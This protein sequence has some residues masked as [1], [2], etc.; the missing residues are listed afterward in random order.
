MKLALTIL[1]PQAQIYSGEA[2]EIIVPTITGEIGILPNHVSLLTQ[3]L[4]GELRVKNAGKTSSFA[5]MGG[6]LEVANNQVNVLGDYAI[7]A[8]DIEVA[9]AQQA[10]ERAEKAKQE[11][12]SLEDLA[13]IEAE[14]RK[15]LL[16]LKVA[17]R[18]KRSS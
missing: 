10:K 17:H 15:S 11:K 1:T 13:T 18:R 5:I 14:L 16:E 3:I 4:P 8:E 6:Y 7:R 2:D 9:K 12:A